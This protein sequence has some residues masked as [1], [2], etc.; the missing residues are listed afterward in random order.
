MQMMRLKTMAR[1]IG[2]VGACAFA[3]LRQTDAAA[4]PPER[5]TFGEAAAPVVD[6]GGEAAGSAEL[7][8]VNE[9]NGRPSATIPFDL[10]F[11]RE[12][13]SPTRSSRCTIL[14]ECRRGGWAQLDAGDARR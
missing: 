3:L 10:L 1:L 8:G 2:F 7:I 6:L 14:P 9:G 5:E 11:A 4:D 12:E 13:R